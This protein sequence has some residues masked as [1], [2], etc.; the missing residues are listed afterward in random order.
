MKRLIEFLCL[1]FSFSVSAQ[2]KVGLIISNPI[3]IQVSDGSIIR[4]YDI[5]IEGNII[6]GVVKHKKSYTGDMKII[7]A[8]GKYLIP[9]LWDMHIH[10][11]GGDSLVQE[12]KNLLPLFIAHGITAVRDAAA[13]LSPYVLKWRAEITNGTLS[14]PTIFTSGPKIEGINSIWVGDI[15][16]GNIPDM[17]KAIDSLQGLNVDFIKIT[18]NT[19]KP[20]IY[21]EAIREAGRR[22]MKIS[23]HIPNALSI[24]QVSAA[25]LSSIEHMSYVLRAGSKDEANIAI[26]FGNGH[27]AARDV[28]PLVL[29]SFDEGYAIE[30]YKRLAKNGTAVV[31]TLSI[32]RI[33][34]YLDQEDHWKDDYLKYLGQGL[35]NT[36]WWRV[37][38]AESD[39]KEAIDLRHRVFQKSASLL[40]L[41][42]KAGVSIIAGTDA[43]YLNSF[44]YP[45]LGLHTELELMV[46]YGLSPLDAL[47]SSIINGP[48][49]FNKQNIYGKIEKGF[50]ADMIL[51]KENPLTSISNTRKIYAVIKSGSYFNRTDL[52]NLLNEAEK[53]AAQGP[54]KPI[55]E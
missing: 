13:D 55:H 22:G 37:K 26:K 31:P 23:G 33:T 27:I 50:M 48:V 24:E 16:V 32:S 21:L 4:G 54:F 11:G 42:K 30:A 40:P 8:S 2:H 47:Q 20:D 41:L 9:G 15:E 3:I 29:G 6:T 5:I 7:D 39:S 49:F 1:F 43:G 12:N 25:G 51:L 19:L 44:D 35:K 10:F 38:R 36:Y 53:N 17:Q 34:A 28:M 45:G 18:D 14:G 52:D 46:K